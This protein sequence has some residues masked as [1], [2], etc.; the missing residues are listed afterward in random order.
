MPAIF[1]KILLR[2]LHFDDKPFALLP[3]TINIKNRGAVKLGLARVFIGRVSQIYNL[4][5]RNNLIEQV[6]QQVFV[7]F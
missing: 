5:V 2:L 1:E 4:M 7:R 6:D 3:N